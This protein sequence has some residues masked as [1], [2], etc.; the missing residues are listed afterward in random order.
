MTDHQDLAGLERALL[1]EIGAA[2]DLAALER[3]RIAALGKKGRI[4]ALMGRLGQLPA[5][6]RKTFGQALNALKGHVAIALEDKKRALEARVRS[7]KLQ[8][9]RADVTL[10]VRAGPPSDGRIHP[11]SQ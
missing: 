10:P 7:A 5:A 1:E 4:S 11:V 3:V 9:E 6:E 8:G 2:G